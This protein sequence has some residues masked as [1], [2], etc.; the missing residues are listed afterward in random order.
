MHDTF[1]RA[2]VILPPLEADRNSNYAVATV[3]SAHN[4]GFVYPVDPY[5]TYHIH[6]RAKAANARKM[7]VKWVN[8][9]HFDVQKMIEYPT[10]FAIMSRSAGPLAVA[11]TVICVRFHLCR[12][13]DFVHICMLN[14]IVAG[15]PLLLFFIRNRA[16]R[17]IF[18][19]CSTRSV[20]LRF[21]Q[22]VCV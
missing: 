21:H 20:F 8:D 9:F 18:L 4:L 17:L 13:I 5:R 14:R 12:L 11:I 19:R 16:N 15:M 7:T 6:G 10:Y 3:A 2:V 1:E 22:T